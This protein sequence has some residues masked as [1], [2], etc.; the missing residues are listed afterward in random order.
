MSAFMLPE[1]IQLLNPLIS[2]LIIAFFWVLWHVPAFLFTYGKEDP[3]LPFVLLVFALSFIFT[4]VYFK[5]GQNILISAVFHACIN[6]SAN[7]ADFSYYE[8]TVLFYWLFAGLMSLIA[9]LLL[10]VT[11]GQLGYDKVE[12]KAY[13]HE[14]HDADLALS[15]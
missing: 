6:A 11:K 3:F 9:I 5:S 14:L 8:D 13:I 15:K 1:L 4:W 12:F 2:T 7:V 10:I